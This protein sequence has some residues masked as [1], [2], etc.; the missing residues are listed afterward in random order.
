M[1]RNII[2]SNK[3]MHVISD[4]NLLYFKSLLSSSYLNNCYKVLRSMFFHQVHYLQIE[5]RISLVKH[6]V[7]Q[8]S[9]SYTAYFS[10]QRRSNQLKSSSFIPILK[11]TLRTKLVQFLR[12]KQ[13]FESNT[14]LYVDC[15]GIPCNQLF[16]KN[17]CT[18]NLL[19][20]Q[21]FILKK[22]NIYEI[23]LKS[24]VARISPDA[25]FQTE[26]YQKLK[27]QFNLYIGQ[28]QQ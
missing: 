19:E 25:S 15:R 9:L 26:K 21:R 22:V 1:F 20:T 4:T 14:H 5:Q 24:F 17:H 28:Y 10:S 6:Q 11:V 18:L 12:F 23:K 3:E 2:T 13:L 8:L 16:Y 7:Y 27:R